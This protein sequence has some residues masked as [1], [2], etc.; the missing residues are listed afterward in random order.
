M[1]FVISVVRML[2][3][4][5]TQFQEK[6]QKTQIKSFLEPQIVYIKV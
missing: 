5:V 3:E 1:Y 2:E 4:K 6:H